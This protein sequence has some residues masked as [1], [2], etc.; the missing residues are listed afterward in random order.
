MRRIVTLAF[1]VQVEMAMMMAYATFNLEGQAAL[2]G[3]MGA[4]TT[5]VMTLAFACA[6]RAQVHLIVRL[7]WAAGELPAD[8]SASLLTGRPATGHTTSSSQS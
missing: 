2:G 7:D 5:T 1:V 8:W 3:T 4:V 6:L